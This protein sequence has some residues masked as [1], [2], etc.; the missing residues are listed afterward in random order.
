MSSDAAPKPNDTSL[1]GIFNAGGRAN[2]SSGQ[3]VTNFISS[4]YTGFTLFGLGILAFLIIK[5]KLFRI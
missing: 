4:L 2:Q 5:Q 3:T 1:S